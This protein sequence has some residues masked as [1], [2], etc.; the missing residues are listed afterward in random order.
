MEDMWRKLDVKDPNCQKKILCELHQNERALGPAASRIVNVFGYAS[1]TFKTCV[2][3]DSMKIHSYARYLSFLNIPDALKNMIEDY[4]DAADRG[5]S[6][7]GGE[8]RDYFDSCEFSLTDTL[9][10]KLKSHAD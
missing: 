6:L 2:N 4:Q 10:K 1:K 5:R 3:I 8:C 9:L 7:N